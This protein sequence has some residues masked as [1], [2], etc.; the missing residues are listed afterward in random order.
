MGGDALIAVRPVMQVQDAAA[1]ITFALPPDTFAHTRADAVVQLSA[2]QVDGQPLPA[3]LVFDPR[4]GSFSGQP[5]AGMEGTVSLRVVARDQDGREAVA[6]VQV[7]VGEAAV[8]PAPEQGQRS[9]NAGHARDKVARLEHHRD[10]A[11]GK[12]AFT[13]QLKMAARNAAIRLA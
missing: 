8:M 1:G 5:P 9:G 3:W 10:H 2:A 7:K 11:P 13:K 12:P 4:T 6:T